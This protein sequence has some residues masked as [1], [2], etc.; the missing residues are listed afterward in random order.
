MQ[1]T[2]VN[3]VKLNPSLREFGERRS[4][5]R[6]IL[7][8]NAVDEPKQM[9]QLDRDEEALVSYRTLENRSLIQRKEQSP[10]VERHP[11]NQVLAASEDCHLCSQQK[12]KAAPHCKFGGAAALEH[13]VKA[14]ASKTGATARCCNSYAGVGGSPKFGAA[15]P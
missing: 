2:C 4:E 7:Q 12:N 3:G 10:G 9:L 15:Q 1:G 11:A 5:S 6:L 13:S 8:R 14:A